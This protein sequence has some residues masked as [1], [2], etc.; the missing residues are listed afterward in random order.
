MLIDKQ[1]QKFLINIKPTAPKLNIYIKTHKD[2]EPIRPVINNTQA[3]SYKLAK[4]VNKKLLHLI[5]LPHTY[6]TKNSQEIVELKSIQIK[7]QMK[8][9]TLDIKDLYVNLPINGIIQTA[10]FWLIRMVTIEN[11]SNTILAGNNFEAKLLSTQQTILPTRKRYS[12]GFS[13]I[14]YNG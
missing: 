1:A 7:E 9:V 11:Y 6:S 2:N 3:P 4:H 12:N 14:Q 8:M 13:H 10:K 5:C